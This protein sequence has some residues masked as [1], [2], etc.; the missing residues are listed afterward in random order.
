MPTIQALLPP[1]CEPSIGGSL[2]AR[3][4]LLVFETTFP[5]LKRTVHTVGRGHEV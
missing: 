4:Q 5:P 2:P 1:R 3:A